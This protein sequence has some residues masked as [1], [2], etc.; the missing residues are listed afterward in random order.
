MCVCLH[1][2]QLPGWPALPGAAFLVLQ[3]QQWSVFQSRSVPRF[4]CR[5]PSLA[6]TLLPVLGPL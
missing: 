2:L 1:P 6:L 5:F 3:S 4:C